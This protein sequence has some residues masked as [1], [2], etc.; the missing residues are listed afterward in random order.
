VDAGIDLVQV[1]ERDLEAASLTDLVLQ[2]LA[3]T[4]SSGT[5]VVVNDRL[6]VARAAGA[7]GVHLRHDSV[8]VGEARSLAPT[9]F[10]IGR[11]VHDVAAAKAAADADYLIAGTVFPTTSKQGAVRLLGL[12]GLRAIVATTTAP[13]LAIGGL[14][15]DHLGAIAATGAAGIAAIGLFSSLQLID[16][17]RE[18]RHRFDRPRSAS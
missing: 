5:R 2:V 16:L 18:A 8:S 13:V 7:D 10:V 17:T 1:R 15:L 9:P 11:S 6:D 4:R 14:T 3:I 12:D